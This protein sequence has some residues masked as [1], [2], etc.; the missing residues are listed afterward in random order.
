MNQRRTRQN[1]LGIVSVII[2]ALLITVVYFAIAITGFERSKT[3]YAAPEAPRLT[4]PQL[5]S[6]LY[7]TGKHREWARCMGVG[8]K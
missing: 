5:C 6:H 3:A 4:K 1:T 7:N 8:Y 2:A